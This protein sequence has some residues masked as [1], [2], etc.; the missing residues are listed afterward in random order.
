MCLRP[1]GITTGAPPHK[2]TATPASGHSLGLAA[3]QT[4]RKVVSRLQQGLPNIYRVRLQLYP[5]P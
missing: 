5:S 3:T 2:T 1:Q 4:S